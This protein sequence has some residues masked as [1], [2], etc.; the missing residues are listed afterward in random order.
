MR[1]S[2][3]QI[4]ISTHV[5][6][7]FP[8]HSPGQLHSPLHLTP[9][10]QHVHGGSHLTWQPHILSEVNLRVMVSIEVNW[11]WNL[12]GESIHPHSVGDGRLITGTKV[13]PQMWPP[14]FAALSV[15]NF[16]ASLPGGMEWNDFPL[17]TKRWRRRESTSWWSSIFWNSRATY[18]FNSG[19]ASLTLSL[20]GPI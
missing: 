2:G 6:L 3:E 15:C 4:T 17:K 18:L 8:K 13:F 5:I 20:E 7:R 14:W 10:T 16:R 19:N 12:A 9:R 11:G 1:Q